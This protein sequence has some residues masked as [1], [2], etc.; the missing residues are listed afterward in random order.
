M[1]GKKMKRLIAILLILLLLL[2]G[3]KKAAQTSA[4]GEDG[5]QEAQPNASD[6][7]AAA[8]FAVKLLKNLQTESGTIFSPAS[9]LF[10][11]GI[12]AD[13]ADSETLS[14]IAD[15]IGMNAK[16]L[17]VFLKDY[18]GGLKNSKSTYS[19]IADSLWINEG[20]VNVK[21]EFTDKFNAEVRSTEFSSKA[22][23]EIN[24]WV[25]DKTNGKI[26]NILDRIPEE[27]LLYIINAT[28]FEGKWEKPFNIKFEREFTKQNG[29]TVK[30]PMMSSAESFFINGENEKGFYK[31]YEGGNYGFIALLPNGDISDYL[32]SLTGGKL[33]ELINSKTSKKV[34]VTI[35]KIRTENH[36]L[37]N[38][39]LKDMGIKSAFD[40]NKADFSQIS[41]DELFIN[42]IIHKAYINVD[43]NGTEAAAST[44]AEAA[45]S[46]NPNEEFLS[47]DRPFIYM[48]IDNQSEQP[49][50][51]GTYMGE[52]LSSTPVFSCGN[53]ITTIHDGDKSYSFMFDDSLW[54]SQL[55]ADLE[56]SPDKLCKCLPKY[57]VDTEYKT[58]YSIDLGETPYARCD[59]GQAE[60]SPEQA[61][62]IE[63]ILQKLRDGKL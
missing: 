58:G 52:G 25:S 54:L 6:K 9:I 41:D 12:L 33:L 39:T 30:I 8:D 32:D 55:L 17:S 36:V 4:P 62:R 51:L 38:D 27:A 22:K 46:S 60:L 11:L 5:M 28:T 20:K 14:E 56:Y 34:Y 1:K 16:D 19:S 50:F 18:K 26:G 61:E 37:L 43:E 31:S 35:P 48:I 42:R 21:K 7:E 47:F 23:D 2:C 63:Q 24:N 40:E 13:G 57:T 29:E 3:C 10:T 59:E 15:A 53:T 45:N 44:I 49:I